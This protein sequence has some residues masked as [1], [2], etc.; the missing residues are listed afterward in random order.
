MTTLCPSPKNELGKSIFP[1][2]VEA[3]LLARGY[4]F[5]SRVPGARFGT[6]VFCKRPIADAVTDGDLDSP[7]FRNRPTQATPHEVVV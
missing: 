1:P 5:A 7:R 2:E 6:R 4:V 3:D